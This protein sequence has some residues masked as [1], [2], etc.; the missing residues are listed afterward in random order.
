MAP[1][2]MSQKADGPK[3]NRKQI[4]VALCLVIAAFAVVYLFNLESWLINDDEG[5][6]LYQAWRI[7]EG[8]IPY[9][10]FFTSRWPLFLY[11]GAG[12]MQLFGPSI[13][14]MR[15]LA[16]ALTLATAI[17]IFLSAHQLLPTKPSML[18]AIIFLLYPDVLYFGRLFQP[19]PFYVFFSTL[20]LYLI[21]MGYKKDRI[22]YFVGAG[23]L[24]AMGTLCKEPAALVVAGTS[25]F[26]FYNWIASRQSRRE[27]FARAAATILPFLI[28]FGIVTAFFLTNVPR[29]YES[30]VGVNLAQGQGSPLSSIGKGLV[31]L[32]LQIIAS[33]AF[34]LTI[35]AAWKSWQ[36]KGV[37]LLLVFQLPTA[38]AFLLLT[39]DLFPRLLLYLAPSIS[40]LFVTSLEPIRQ[41][42]RKSLLLATIIGTITL[43]WI[44]S[45]IHLLVQEEQATEQ[46]VQLIQN[47]IP[48]DA[49]L[50]SDYQELNFHAQRRSTYLGAEISYV[51]VAGGS[52]TGEE[53][54]NE[55]VKNEVAMVI[56]DVSPNTGNHLHKL[57][58]LDLFY[59]HLDK[60]YSLSWTIS[61]GDQIL[62][63]YSYQ[64]RD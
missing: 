59:D 64:D 4:T 35:P 34:L 58:D 38:F 49:Y 8:E 29:F 10:D 45:D 25:L 31:F 26:M 5:S 33:P 13:M 39:R 61:R 56:I 18:S 46:T 14:P 15:I 24:F 55:M 6:F 22:G 2:P 28:L 7:S 23:T 36:K 19:E 63:I 17:L 1:I 30:V 50:L 53:L 42:P 9:Q 43:P 51:V 21:T 20:G 32:T 27:S 11:S 41:L 52:I 40:I 54:I 62:N 37:S 12:W 60:Y 16:V 48:P 57:R 3:A 47:E 44:I